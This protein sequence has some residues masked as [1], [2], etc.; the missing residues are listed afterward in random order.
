MPKLKPPKDEVYCPWCGALLQ[1]DVFCDATRV[2][3]DRYGDGEIEL[4][5]EDTE[6]NT[7]EVVAYQCSKYECQYEFT[8]ESDRQ[9]LRERF[10]R[11]LARIETIPVLPDEAAPEL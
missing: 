7:C 4:D 3:I 8:T 1:M 6:Y 9:N 2:Y 10:E 5:A 11:V